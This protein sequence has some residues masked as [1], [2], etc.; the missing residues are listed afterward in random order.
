[1]PGGELM[2]EDLSL[3]DSPTLLKSKITAV[4]IPARLDRLE[5]L[6]FDLKQ[7]DRTNPCN[8]PTYKIEG[9]RDG[10]P[11][12]LLLMRSNTD[13]NPNCLDKLSYPVIPEVEWVSPKRESEIL[14]KLGARAG[15][16]KIREEK[17]RFKAYQALDR[18]PNLRAFFSS[19]RKQKETFGA[20]DHLKIPTQQFAPC[21]EYEIWVRDM[22]GSEHLH[23]RAI[24]GK[25]GHFKAYKPSTA[26]KAV[27]KAKPPIDP[28]APAGNSSAASADLAL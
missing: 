5:S 16:E 18:D 11:G 17:K 22:D 28:N 9:P 13:V 27:S 25:N 6:E 21:E 15:A 23:A 2:L 8:Q 1:M 10:K 26:V 14:A 12:K 7:P 3:A 19:E 20:S 24:F 4:V